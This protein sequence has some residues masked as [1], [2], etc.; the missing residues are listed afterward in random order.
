[1][2]QG[3]SL[4]MPSG[5][6]SFSTRIHIILKQWRSILFQSPSAL[7]R[8]NHSACSIILRRLNPLWKHMDVCSSAVLVS[9]F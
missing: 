1:M 6:A 3:G 4:W 9:S 5:Q 7:T 2:F 8:D